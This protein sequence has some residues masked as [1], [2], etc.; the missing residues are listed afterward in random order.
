MLRVNQPPEDIR[1]HAPDIDEQLAEIIMRGLEPSPNDR[2]PG[3]AKMLEALEEVRQRQGAE[4]K[5][6]SKKKSD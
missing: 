3:M 4:V 1:Q 6:Q 5:G 2:W